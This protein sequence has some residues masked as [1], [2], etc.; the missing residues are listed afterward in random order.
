MIKDYE[1]KMVKFQ[2]GSYNGL[3]EKMHGLGFTVTLKRPSSHTQILF[4]EYDE[5]ID[6]INNH[7]KEYDKMVE[8]DKLTDKYCSENSWTTSGS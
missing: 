2:T 3:G 8:I 6:T 4:D 5:A 1:N 7:C